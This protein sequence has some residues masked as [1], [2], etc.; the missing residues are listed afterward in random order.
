MAKV[1]ITKIL[2]K[3][4]EIYD[5]I[6][7]QLIASDEIGQLVRLHYPPTWISSTV[8]QFDDWGGSASINGK[9]SLEQN[10]EAQK[11]SEVTEEIRMRVYST[12]AQGFGRSIFRALAGTKYVEGQLLTIGLMSDY[13]KVSGCIKADFYIETESVTGLKTYKLATDVRPHGFGKDKFFFCF[14][15][16][17]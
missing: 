6:C 15:E 13:G 17:V 10:G 9:P 8:N 5:D 3:T 7:L 4:K 2:S 16:K 14:W 11:Q 12:D 1:N